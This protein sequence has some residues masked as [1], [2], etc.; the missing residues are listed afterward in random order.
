MKEA[1][2]ILDEYSISATA[3]KFVY[4]I[5]TI[6]LYMKATQILVNE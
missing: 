4:G 3:W 6:R 5:E 2:K 1:H